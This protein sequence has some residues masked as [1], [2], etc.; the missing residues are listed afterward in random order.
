MSVLS[1]IDPSEMKHQGNKGSHA[2]NS[3]VI[4]LDVSFILTMYYAATSRQSSSHTL[5]EVNRQIILLS[6]VKLTATLQFFYTVGE[7]DAQIKHNWCHLYITVG[8]NMIIPL[9]RITHL[10][11]AVDS[12]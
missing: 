6:A 3:S 4:F 10:C 11:L 12:C 9:I 8:T 7:R 5:D 1:Q 2:C